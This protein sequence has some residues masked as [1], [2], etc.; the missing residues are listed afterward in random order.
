MANKV[1]RSTAFC[2]FCGREQVIPL[3]VQIDYEIDLEEYAYQICSCK[4]SKSFYTVQGAREG[5]KDLFRDE[6]GKST[7]PDE[8]LKALGL[9]VSAI[10]RE[11]METASFRLGNTVLKINTNKDGQI[12][13]ERKDVHKQEVVA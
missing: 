2:K 9:I 10:V 4:D 6:K 3:D 8:T 11:D 7:M 5:I 13:I 12:K 1:D